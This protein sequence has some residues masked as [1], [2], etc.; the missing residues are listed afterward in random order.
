MTSLNKLCAAAAR[1]E[2]R[3]AA[4]TRTLGRVN[5]LLPFAAALVALRLAGGLLGRWRERRD[6]ALLT[7]AGALL[8]YEIGR[9][10]V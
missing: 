2:A 6:P 8:A 5:A 1:A 9:A 4:A 7:W 10:H 3:G